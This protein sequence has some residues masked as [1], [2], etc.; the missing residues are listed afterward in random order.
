MKVGLATTLSIAG[1]LTA[2][3]AALAVNSSVLSGNSDVAVGL[4]ATSNSDATKPASDASGATLTN[5]S[6]GTVGAA[7]VT[8]DGTTNSGVTTYSVGEAGSVVIDTSS[9]SIV[10]RDVVPNSGWK[11]LLVLPQPN[12]GYKFHFVNGSKRIELRLSIDANGRITAV[13]SDE[14]GQSTPP[15]YTPNY[16]T[17]PTDSVPAFLSGDDDDDD[18][19][20]GDDDSHDDDGAEDV[21]DD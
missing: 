21:D 8:L 18:D 4:P 13:M 5:I 11:S 17:S 7:D 20:S 6:D 3:A 9:G 19:H 16:P 10:V 12:G 14:S 15:A 1:V 2:G